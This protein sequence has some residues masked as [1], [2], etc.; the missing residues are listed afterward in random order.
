[1][2]VFVL[3]QGKGAF[4]SA[5]SEQLIRR[6]ENNRPVHSRRLEKR[7]SLARTVELL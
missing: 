6:P 5:G 7:R 3:A 2:L 1:M 4:Q